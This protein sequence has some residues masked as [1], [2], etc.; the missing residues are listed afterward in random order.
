MNLDD[1]FK[2]PK[3][4]QKAMDKIGKANKQKEKIDKFRFWFPVIVSIIALIASTYFAVQL[5]NKS[6]IEGQL[7][8][9]SQEI[10]KLSNDLNNLYRQVDKVDIALVKIQEK[11]TKKDTLILI[12][13]F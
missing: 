8:K 4:N 13:S 2:T 3:I 1:K 6:D 10:Q 7:H 5:Y 11:K 12:H 9:Q